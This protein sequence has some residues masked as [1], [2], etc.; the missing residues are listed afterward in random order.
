MAIL[1][2]SK[3]SIKLCIMIIPIIFALIFI[4]FQFSYQMRLLD[5][6]AKV[7]YYDTLYINSSLLLNADRDFYEATLAERIITESSL[8]QNTKNRYL[9]V[10]NENCSQIQNN[11]N[12]MI[13]NIKPNKELY[14]EYKHSK[15]QLTMS[16]LSKQFTEQFKE[17]QVSFDPN[18]G[19]GFIVAKNAM[20]DGIRDEIKTMTELLDE[21]SQKSQL[22]MQNYIDIIRLRIFVLVAIA[23][24]LMAFICIYIVRFIVSNM[25]A[26]TNNMHLLSINNLSFNPH[27]SNSKDEIGTLSSSVSVLVLS[28]RG[29][30][31]KLLNT[32]YHL[33]TSSSTMKIASDEVTTSMSEISRT[34]C[35]LAEGSASQAEDTQ[36]LVDEITNL[37]EAVLTSTQS[38]KKLS[39]TTHKIMLISQEG[40]ETVTNLDDINK[41]NQSAFRSIF[42]TIDIVNRN[43]SKIMESAT[44][45]SEIA[46]EINLISLNTNIEASKASTTGRGFTVIAKEIHKL[47]E[48][49]KTATLLINSMLCHITN[50]INI[51]SQQCN[52]VDNAVSLQTKCVLETKNN[53]SSIVNMLD[54]I[55]NEIIVLETVSK[56]IEE[57]RSFISLF[58]S[59]VSA[60]SEEYA[61]S[62]QEASAV[63]EQV[64][65][66]ITNINQ[67]GNKV[68]DLA[69]ELKDIISKFTL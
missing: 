39:Q 68:D 28:L 44:M 7:T 16:Q 65:S 51:A 48:Q 17:W 1:R 62:T 20:F 34:I 42:Q 69:S 33:A 12:T 52:E 29:I 25:K 49:T 18:T 22:D 67:I 32:S 45:I 53:Y 35:E 47:S 57:S 30:V 24:L 43:T 38:T 9:T 5:N 6:E 23:S 50:N 10:Y 61:A 41:Q 37:G 19:T 13:S 56:K 36:K 3:I 64:L 63:T 31:E 59:N 40:L 4:L 14:S 8:D 58:S 21:Y 2:N 27:L 60:V 26:L 11:I 15:T 66:S 54:I 46:E 55:N